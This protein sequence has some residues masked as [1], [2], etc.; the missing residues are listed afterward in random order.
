MNLLTIIDDLK[1]KILDSNPDIRIGYLLKEML[2]KS[3]TTID[4]SEMMRQALERE[5]GG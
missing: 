3:K 1:E 2:V 4:V 5:E